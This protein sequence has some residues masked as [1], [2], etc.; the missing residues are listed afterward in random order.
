MPGLTKRPGGF[1]GI[2]RQDLIGQD[3]TFPEKP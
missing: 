3:R 1:F 2:L